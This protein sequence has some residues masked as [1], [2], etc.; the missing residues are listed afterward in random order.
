MTVYQA[1]TLERAF[2][3]VFRK[4]LSQSVTFYSLPELL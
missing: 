2:S 1:K 3:Y 4:E